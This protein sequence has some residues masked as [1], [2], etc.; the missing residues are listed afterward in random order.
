ME[1]YGM[2]S[3]RIVVYYL[4]KKQKYNNTTEREGK[5]NGM[6]EK[7]GEMECMC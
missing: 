4:L 6:V 7:K 5:W 2:E 1:W 3:N